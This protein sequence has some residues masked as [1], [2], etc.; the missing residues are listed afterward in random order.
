[1]KLDRVWLELADGAALVEGQEVTLMDW[2]N[3]LIKVRELQQ[4]SALRRL[5]SLA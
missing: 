3:A 1:V 5:S 4:C 2:G